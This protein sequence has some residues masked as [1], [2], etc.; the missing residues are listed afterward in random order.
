MND[1]T[2]EQKRSKTKK[3][4][5]EEEGE[6][7]KKSEEENKPIAHRQSYKKENK[8]NQING[9]DHDHCVNVRKPWSRIPNKTPR[10]TS[11]IIRLSH[12]RP[13]ASLVAAAPITLA[14]A[15]GTAFCS[16]R[17]RAWARVR[18]RSAEDDDDDDDDDGEDDRMP[19]P[20][21]VEE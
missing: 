2:R 9:Q 17:C 5:R 18:L 8:R 6:K 21:T 7:E 13:T 14:T 20:S 12:T 10:D 11:L 15:A 16:A 19:D 1:I 3:K 4:K